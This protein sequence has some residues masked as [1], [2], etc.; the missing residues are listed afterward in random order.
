MGRRKSIYPS[1]TSRGPCRYKRLILHAWA[2]PK[3]GWRTVK[4][5]PAATGG[6]VQTINQ[7][8]SVERTDSVMSDSGDSSP[9]LRFVDFVVG[10]A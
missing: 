8:I 5:K 1:T 2:P 6:D 9:F 3:V 4:I 10:S 7:C